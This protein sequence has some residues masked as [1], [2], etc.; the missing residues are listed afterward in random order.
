MEIINEEPKTELKVKSQ[1]FL[2]SSSSAEDLPEE[3][4]VFKL[5]EFK[6]NHMYD[7]LYI[8]LRFE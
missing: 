4:E 5:D 6:Y 7:L 8:P 3:N 1:E 2:S